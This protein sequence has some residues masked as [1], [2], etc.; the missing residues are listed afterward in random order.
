MFHVLQN[1]EIVTASPPNIPICDYEGSDYRT[2]FWQNQGREYEDLSE[3]IALHKLMPPTGERLLEIGTGFGRLVDMYQ[4]YRQIVLLDYSRSLL[5]EA[6]GRLGAAPQYI[7]SVGNVY[8][9]PFDA[10]QFDTVCLIRV[11]HHLADVPLALSQIAHVLKPGGALI[12]EFASKLHLKSILRHAGRRQ[13]WSPFAPEPVEFVELNFDFHPRWMQQQLA[14]HGFRVERVRSLSHLRIPLLKRIVPA[15][16]LAAF[17]RLLQP[18]G[19][20]WPVAPSIMLRARRAGGPPAGS[21]AL[22]FRCPSCGS[23][24]LEPAPAMLRCTS[25]GARWP[26]QDGIYDF[27][28]PTQP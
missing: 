2:R 28:T 18:S 23:T 6:Q 14:A 4:G 8:Q 20:W 13:T 27:K 22:A 5:Q 17:D 19:Q 24:A 9:L 7:Y 1:E 15:R 16:L 11:I 26:T 3:R 25:C 12:L 21:G 10:A